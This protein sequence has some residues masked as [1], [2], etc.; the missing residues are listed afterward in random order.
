MFVDSAVI[1]VMEVCFCCKEPSIGTIDGQFACL[2]C[3]TTFTKPENCV[4]KTCAKCASREG[5]ATCPCGYAGDIQ[6][7]CPW[8]QYSR[9]EDYMSY[10]P[11]STGSWTCEK[12]GLQEIMTPFC[13]RCVE[14]LPEEFK[15]SEERKSGKTVTRC[16]PEPVECLEEIVE[17]GAKIWTCVCCGYEYNNDAFC[18]ICGREA[19]TSPEIDKTTPNPPPVPEST[20]KCQE[21]GLDNFSSRSNC[22]SCDC[23]QIVTGPF[24]I[25]CGAYNSSEFLSCRKCRA[26]LPQPLKPPTCQQCG[27]TLVDVNAPCANCVA[28]PAPPK[29]KS[30]WCTLRDKGR[31]LVG[32]FF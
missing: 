15:D 25:A 4:E 31:R 8:C 1:R 22:V 26:F 2:L 6:P 29:K 12:C 32:K 14:D 5:K 13:P 9:L 17:A 7:C 28:A 3:L 21:C 16:E 23:P 10:K 27:A 20:W 19:G 18:V 11:N 30:K 24:C